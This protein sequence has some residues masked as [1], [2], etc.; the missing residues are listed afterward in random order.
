MKKFFII[1]GGVVIV[2]ILVIVTGLYFFM[3]GPDISLYEHLKHPQITEKPDQNMLVVKAQGDPNYVAPGAFGLLFEIYYKM[4]ETEKSFTMPV[5]R[6]R[7]PIS[8]ETPKDQWI[9]LYALAIP[10]TITQLP[11]YDQTNGLSASLEVWHYG[12]VAEILHIGPYDKEESTVN[13][14]KE[15]IARHGFIVN[16]DHEEEY[17]KST[18]M[19]GTGDPEEYATIIRYPVVKAEIDSM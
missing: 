1:A 13:L 8:L 2:I 15:Y 3:Q 6:A 10:K 16:G 4:E 18:G 5:P 7:W 14:L 11:E 12:M 9:G 19:F 17:L